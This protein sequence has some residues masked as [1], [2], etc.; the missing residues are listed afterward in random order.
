MNEK[1][2]ELFEIVGVNPEMRHPSDPSDATAING[3][4]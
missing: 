2:K 1:L 3:E 4:H